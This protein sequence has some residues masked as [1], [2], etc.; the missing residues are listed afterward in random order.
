MK[1]CPVC[2]VGCDCE[3]RGILNYLQHE[4]TGSAIY[5]HCSKCGKEIDITING[6][7]WNCYNKQACN[8]MY[9]NYGWICPKCGR[10]NSPSTLTCPCVP[11]KW[12]ITCD[13]TSVTG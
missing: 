3:H 8:P 5:S 9:Y 6:M 1:P 10:G 11:I 2:G 4:T 12:E 7:C 13:T